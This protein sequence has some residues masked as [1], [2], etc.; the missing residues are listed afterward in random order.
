MKKVIAILT[1]CSFVLLSG[2]TAKPTET[3][4][5]G[6]TTAPQQTT[7]VQPTNNNDVGGYLCRKLISEIEGEYLKEKEN[8]PDGLTKAEYCDLTEE[9]AN[10]WKQAADEYYNK[11]MEYDLGTQVSEA[12]PTTEEFHKALSNM[13]KNREEYHNEELSNYITALQYKY[14]AGTIV[15]TFFAK[16]EYEMQ[17][18]WALKKN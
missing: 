2:C 8:D 11:L 3:D 12:Y 14:T 10:K 17:K 16:Y 13:K 18:E 7:T 15:T 5:Q 1:V 9:Y 6:T 4:A